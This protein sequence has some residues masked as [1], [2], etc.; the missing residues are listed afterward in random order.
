MENDQS[1]ESQKNL[2]D[3]FGDP[4]LDHLLLIFGN[5]PN[6]QIN[7]KNWVQ[8]N[9]TDKYLENQTMNIIGNFQTMK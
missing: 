8:I 6:Y 9:L 5:P 2:L 4:I 3:S 1:Q 7:F